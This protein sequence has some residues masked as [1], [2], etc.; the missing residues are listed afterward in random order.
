MKKKSL[1]TSFVAVVFVISIILLFAHTTTSTPVNNSP[2]TTI[3][4]HVIGCPNCNE[5]YYCIDGVY[6]GVAGGCDFKIECTP[7]KHTICVKCAL[8]LDAGGSCTFDCNSGTD[9]ITIDVNNSKSCDCYPS[10]KK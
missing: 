3:L 1:I 5:I 10:K 4:V 7:G 9:Q 2:E 8:S 6:T